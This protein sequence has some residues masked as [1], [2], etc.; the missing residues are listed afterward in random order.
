MGSVRG[1]LPRHQPSD[2][3]V[4]LQCDDLTEL[5]GLGDVSATLLAEQGIHSFETL[6]SLDPDALGWLEK[7]L[8]PLLARLR[9]HDWIGQAE[10]RLQHPER[11]PTAA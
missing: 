9:R 1:S 8:A 4:P 2:E 10:R 6:A 5:S 7:P 11:L 3:G